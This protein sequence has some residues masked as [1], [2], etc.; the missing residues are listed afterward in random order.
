MKNTKILKNKLI[1]LEN[2]INSNPGFNIKLNQQG[3]T[4]EK[5]SFSGGN[6]RVWISPFHEQYD[7]ALSGKSL[8]IEMYN[9][10]RELC[11]RVPDGYK[12]T[13]NNKATF[14]APFWR[15]SDFKLVK[16]ATYYYAGT[17]K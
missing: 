4:K 8:V 16:E 9:F 12:Q 6:G 10:M 13:N 7:I 5:M 3:K 2:D 14:E 15:V 11:G 1:Q 17:R